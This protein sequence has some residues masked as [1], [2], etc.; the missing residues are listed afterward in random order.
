M[1]FAEEEAAVRVV[2]ECRCGTW[3]LQHQLHPRAEEADQL[4]V[5]DRARHRERKDVR[6]RGKRRGSR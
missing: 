3:Q 1:L 6:G 4:G 2:C 5:L